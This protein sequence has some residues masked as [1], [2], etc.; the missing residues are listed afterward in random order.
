MDEFKLDTMDLFAQLDSVLEE[1]LVSR[2]RLAS[3]ER[4]IEA[5]KLKVAE[6]NKEISRLKDQQT[7]IKKDFARQKAQK[8][9]ELKQQD[10]NIRNKLANIVSEN[11]G[12]DENAE[13]W[14][15]LIEVLVNEIDECI[16][17]IR[18]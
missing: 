5:L 4:Q 7:Q 18:S 10:F 17:I 11:L 15:Q 16:Q 12:E 8:E 9:S 1:I 2:R 3:Q 13:V 14:K 6:Q